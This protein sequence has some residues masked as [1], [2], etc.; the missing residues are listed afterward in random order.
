MVESRP[1]S[2]IAHVF[3]GRQR[4]MAELTAALDEALAGEGRLVLLAGEPGIGKTRTAQ[5][6]AVL[7]EQRGARVLWGRCYEGEGA[8]PYW[9][10]TQPLRSYVQQSSAEQLTA[11]MGP[12]AADIAEI[13]AGIRNKLSDLPISPAL[14]PEQARFRLFDSVTT[15]LKNLARRQPLM[16]VLDDLHWADR[17]SLLLLEFLAR[18]LGESRLLLMG[19]YRHAE[20]SR[21][22]AL[23]ETFAEVSREPVFRRQVLRGMG[24][25]ELGQFI[26][27]SAGV[28]LSQEFTDTLYA[29]TEGNPFFIT[30]VIR[31]LSDSGELSTGHAVTPEGLRMP[32][33]VREVIGQRLNRLS[34][35][36]NDVLITAS[37]IGR[38]F[39]F[40]LLGYLSREGNEDEV[41]E[42]LEEALA[43]GVIE[44]PPGTTGR[45]GFTH[46]LIQETLVQELSTTRR[47]RLHSRVGQGLEEMYADNIEAHAA[48]LAHHFAQSAA[49]TGS[50]KLIRYSLLAGEQALVYY[51]Y[52]EA[53][54]YFQRALEAKRVSLTGSDP[55]PDLEAAALLRGLGLAQWGTEPRRMLSAGVVNL[56]RAFDYYYDSG[57]LADVVAIAEISIFPLA[58]S[59]TAMARLIHRA[60]ELIPV[61]SHQ[62]G[63]LQSRYGITVG[64]AH[65]DYHAAQA[66]FSH[67]VAIAQA[68]SDGDLEARALAD[69]ATT[70]VFHGYWKES[71]EKALQAIELAQGTGNIQTLV[72]AHYA[73]IDSLHRLG[74]MAGM[75]HHAE[76]LLDTAQHLR[77]RYWLAT[78]W[79]RLEIIARSE[80]DWTAARGFSDHGLVYSPA[81]P[82]LLGN[83]V[84][85][86][87]ETGDLTAG[88]VYLER[89]LESLRQQER[90]PTPVFGITAAIIG[91]TA[92]ISGTAA[93]LDAAEKAARTVL[94]FPE[95][96]PAF[97]KWAAVA[98]GFLAVLR[99]DRGSAAEQHTVLEP[100]GQIIW[101]FSI[102]NGRVLGL[103]SSLLEQY[104]RA[105]AEFEGNLEYCGRAGYLP[106][107]AWTYHDYA[108][109]LL[110]RD[111]NGDRAKAH[112]LLDQALAI[113]VP[114]VM[115]PLS[116][117]VKALL[118]RAGTQGTASRV[119]PSGLTERE[120]EVLRLIAAGK[121][122]RDI[123]EAL[124]IG[125]RTVSTHVGN[126]LNKVGAAN[127]TEAATYANKLGLI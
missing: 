63:W 30:E 37:I 72:L 110:C 67:A 23:A 55:A 12:G 89:L 102:A 31:L 121:T 15:F 94:E 117:R 3:I 119:H 81:D 115:E 76:A 51:A 107:L 18:E 39:D 2:G 10:W 84:L 28:Q 9:P 124:V 101:M 41:L 11:E 38:E 126:I 17:S 49:V 73:A 65:G 5:E 4:E 104:D 85:T 45:Y 64:Q 19:C 56:T 13:V 1:I 100:A 32:E 16:L 24:Q 54:D 113:T 29:H 48:E 118:E 122:D 27:A 99:E 68:H 96:P 36:C 75:R 8:P 78:A 77:D 103:L 116:G 62:A 69:S 92:R 66:A 97:I 105:V 26:E 98:L 59:R 71:A 79:S 93:R 114:L 58:G 40:R 88:E 57:D 111:G 109:M 90:A 20:L 60:L 14:E 123:A 6:L 120:V 46:A 74:D 7:A 70:D 52:E 95:A 53:L 82:R 22:H 125:V 87:Y 33:G 34:E 106:E 61:G 86:E 44:E 42:A 35:Q 108:E 112:E 83:R 91:H 80:G 25:D 127:R 21:Q 43:A 47:A 50:G